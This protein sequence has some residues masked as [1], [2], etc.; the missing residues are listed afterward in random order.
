MPELPEVETIVR[1]CRPHLEGRRILRFKTHWP[2]NT[3]PGAA[4]VARAL[5]GRKIVQVTRRAKFVVFQLDDGACLLI[6]LR[7][8]G[9]LEWDEPQSKA[10]VPARPGTHGGDG[11]GGGRRGGPPHSNGSPRHVRAVW[12]LDNGRR[13]LFCDARKFGRIRY[14][15]DLAAATRELGPEPL[16]RA[17]APACLE[18]LLA[19]RRRQLKPLLLDQRV[20]AGLG[21]IYTDEALFRAGLHPATSSHRLDREQVRRLHRGIR[22]VL[23][24]AI[25]SHGTT[26]DWIYPGGWMQRRLNVYGRTGQPC[27]TCG[28]PIVA[29]RIGQRGTHICPRCQP[30]R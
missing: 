26:I 2:K 8:S 22:D 30:K 25:R 5:S 17:F 7:M 23:R 20:I 16:A 6:H 11:H 19:A 28:T 3:A 4:T 15:R 10:G 9:R 13:L 1:N 24:L 18:K 14:T 21:N 29:L 12:D 27:R